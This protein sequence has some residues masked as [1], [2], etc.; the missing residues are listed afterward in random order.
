MAAAFGAFLLAGCD[1]RKS[2][3]TPGGQ[4]ATG[5]ARDV[6]A[7]ALAGLDTQPD[8]DKCRTA[9]QQLDNLESTSR[10][11]TLTDAEK[12]DLASLLKLNPAERGEI[13]QTTFSQ[14]D[15]AYLEECLLVRA[16]VRALKIDDR[17]PLERARL[18]FEWVCR[19]V[20]VDDRVPLPANPWTTLQCGSGIALS[21]AYV[22]LAAWQQ[23]GLDGCLV[24]PA[25]LATTPS[26]TLPGPVNA[27]GQPTFAPVRACG[28]RIESDV[29]L[30]DP[31]GGI[32][33]PAAD[34]KS[35]LT[36][37]QAKEMPQT[38]KG[39]AKEDEV[40]T[41]QPF[42]APPLPALSRRMEWL[43]RLN[44]GGLGAKLFVDLAGQRAKAEPTSAAVWFPEGDVHSAGR[45]LAR[46]AAEEATPTMVPLRQRHR[47]GM[48]PLE[49]F[50]KTN[51]A[52]N[53]LAHVRMSYAR[54]FDMLRYTPNSARDHLLRGQLG[55][56]LT[57]LDDLKKLIDNARARFDQDK[58][59]QEDFERWSNEFQAVSAQLIRAERDDPANVP[60]AR[61]AFEQFRIQ[62]KNMDIERAF[63][64]GHA[65]RPLAAEVTFLMAS[66]VHERA[67]R[68][69]LD[70]SAQA[71]GHWRNA[72]D[73]WVRFLDASAQARALFPAR[74]P[75]ARALLARCQQFVKK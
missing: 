5:P 9:L 29:Y 6:E 55:E 10:R 47:I 63:V 19:M 22:V 42:L 43:E 27:D 15:A 74:E 67:E 73:W 16:G 68:A 75:H 58:G 34:G 40:K 25:T 8:L 66:T 49:Q 11:P 54:P 45:V 36:L 1:A 4:P 21:R 65:A 44:P 2:A 51:L 62:P 50:P 69:Q 72:R 24:G 18:G 23:L 61:R 46:Y 60:A 39:L 31:A 33:V 38:V 3:T 41:W 56:A 17:P 53:A 7:T 14:T 71:A 35:V 57:A 26:M 32:V 64:L 20:Y 30:F 13:G 59:L 28:V 12:A 52:G 70:G 37:A 48:I